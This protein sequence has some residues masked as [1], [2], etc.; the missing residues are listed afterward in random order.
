[1]YDQCDASAGEATL[2]LAAAEAF[3][4]IPSVY[5]NV[6]EMLNERQER[7]EQKN[8]QVMAIMDIH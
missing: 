6:L 8:F 7:D 1:M 3:E 2:Q 4:V 5:Q